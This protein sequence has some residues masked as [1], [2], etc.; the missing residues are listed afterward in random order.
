MFLLAGRRGAHLVGAIAD[1]CVVML[2]SFSGAHSVWGSWALDYLGESVS[3]GLAFFCLTTLFGSLAYMLVIMAKL[4]RFNSFFM[5]LPPTVLIILDILFF[6]LDVSWFYTLR[7]AFYVVN[8]AI[9]GYV[10]F[11]LARSLMRGDS[12]SILLL[13]A[14][15]FLTVFFTFAVCYDFQNH[16]KSWA[17][18]LVLFLYMVIID[19]ILIVNSGLRVTKS[20]TERWTAPL[21]H[22][23]ELLLNSNHSKDRFLSI[24]AHDLKNPIA[25]IK[26]LSNIYMEDAMKHNSDHGKDLAVA[27]SDSIDNISKLLENLLTWTRSQN[28]TINCVPRTIEVSQM[29]EQLKYSVDPVC[30]AKHISLRFSANGINTIYADPDMMQT[31]LRNLVTNAV[32]FSYQDNFVDLD[33]SSDNQNYLIRVTDYGVGMSPDVIQKLFKI[34][35]IYSSTGTLHEHGTGLGLILCN[36]F[37]QKHGGNISVL[38]D[39]GLG[40]TFLVTL[41][42]VH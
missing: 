13:L 41:P 21:N 39:E 30:S 35:Q 28:G 8:F 9:L 11:Q 12:N 18:Y 23:I 40:T 38:S 17:D 31:V 15:T 2:M 7:H 42:K 20:K 5:V 1:I 19:I 25:S 26:M 33:F 36:E 24:I 6:V 37:V 16:A 27:L 10:Y 3:R 32:K 4:P 29:I 14:N 34:D 22:Q